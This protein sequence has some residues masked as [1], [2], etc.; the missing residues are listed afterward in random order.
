[1]A[2][3]TFAQLLDDF[4]FLDDWEE[5]YKY[6]IELG[7]GLEPLADAERGLITLGITPT[8]PATAYG[9]VHRGAA[10]VLFVQFVAELQDLPCPVHPAPL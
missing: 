3:P 10:D 9:Y 7:R 4:E 6:V 2:E 5:R 1:M 8:H